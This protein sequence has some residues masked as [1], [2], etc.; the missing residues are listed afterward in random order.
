VPDG[1]NPNATSYLVYDDSNPFP[2]A[3]LVDAWS[4]YDD[5]T[6]VPQNGEKR[7]PK[8]DLTLTLDVKMDNLGDGA[9]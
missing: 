9:N 1:L 8:P 2:D 5:S 6:L 4:D 7:L 3:A